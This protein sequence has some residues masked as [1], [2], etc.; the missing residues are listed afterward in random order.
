MPKGKGYPKKKAAPKKK[1]FAGMGK[2]FIVKRKGPKPKDGKPKL[3][4]FK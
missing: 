4:G 3:R 1:P 2:D